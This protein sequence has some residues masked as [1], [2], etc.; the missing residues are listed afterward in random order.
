MNTFLGVAGA[1]GGLVAFAI[2]VVTIVRAIFGQVSATKDN[3]SALRDLI[4]K[5]EHID[6]TVDQHGQRIASLDS[7]TTQHGER[8]ARLEEGR[9][10]AR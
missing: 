7:T 9:M 1:L 5:F 10:I 8:I 3:T 6:G 2:A 4:A